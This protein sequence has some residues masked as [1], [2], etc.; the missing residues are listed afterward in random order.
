[1]K[2][3]ANA[4]GTLRRIEAWRAARPDL[5]VRS[6]FIVGFPG[7][8]DREFEELLAFLEAAQLDR[9]GCFAYSPVEGAT[10]NDL[11][12]PVPDAIK[13]ERR[14]RFMAVQARISAARLQQRVG[15]VL[16]VLVDGHDE[17][18]TAVARSAADAPEIDGVVRVRD[19]QAL[20]TGTFARVEVTAADE[21]DLEAIALP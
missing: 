6:T 16:Q 18:G 2:R 7:E 9:V 3:P 21:H 10:A 8:S 13:E 15:S 1:M 11:P 14:A 12:D 19:G 17:H 5:V 20:R 4:E